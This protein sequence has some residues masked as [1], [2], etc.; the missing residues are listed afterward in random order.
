MPARTESTCR[1]IR[2]STTQEVKQGA[3]YFPG[4]SAESAGARGIC[5]HL[6]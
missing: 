2:P 6:E 1:L 5:M 4:I 3:T